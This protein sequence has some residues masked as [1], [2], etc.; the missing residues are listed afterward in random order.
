MIKKISFFL[1]LSMSLTLLGQNFDKYKYVIVASKFDFLKKTDHY[2][3]SSLTKFLLKKKGFTVY[4]DNEDLPEEVVNNRCLALSVEVVDESTMLTTKNAIQFKDCYGKVVYKSEVGKSKIKEYQKAYFE[5]IRKAYA[6]MEDLEYNF[7][8]LTEIKKQIENKNEVPKI[9]NITPKVVAIPK[10]SIKQNQLLSK[11]SNENT[12]TLYA[13]PKGNGY[14][15]IN[16]KPEV[17]FVLL[18]TNK[19]GVFIIKGKNGTLT[20][21]GD[22]W[23]AE[24][25]ENDMLVVKNYVIK[26]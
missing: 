23:V 6:S 16:L 8:P 9:N 10:E 7:K 14:Q 13:Q 3:T 11:S 4:L 19:E 2:Q 18:K 22:K 1:L 20:K 24:Y 12:T 17:V 26:F 15:L 5:T 21:Q 25:Y